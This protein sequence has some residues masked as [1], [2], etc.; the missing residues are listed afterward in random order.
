[1]KKILLLLITVIC[2]L[3]ASAQIGRE[4]TGVLRDSTGQSV[5]GATIR[6]TSPSDTLSVSSNV[7]GAFTFRNVKS[8]QFLLSISS[9]GYQ[10]LNKRFLFKEGTTPLQ[11]EPIVLKTASNV[12]NEVQV[13]ATRG[14]T[15]KEDT[16]EYRAAD[17]PVRENSV[18]EDIIKK[19][20]GVEVDRE[21]NVTTQGKSVTRVRVNGRDYFEGDLKTATQNLP[22]E[23]IDKIQIIDDYGDQAAITGIREGEADKIINIQLRTN[24]G[25]VINGTGGLGSQERYQLTGN[26]QFMN[27]DQQLAI[28][29]NLNNNNA[30]PFSFGGGGGRG[31]GGGGGRS[32]N[33]GGSFSGG[34]FGGGGG[35]GNNSG[36]ITNTT[37]GGLNFRDD[38]GK[39]VK[40][41][42]SYRFMSRNTDLISN[43]VRT[44]FIR[45]TTRTNTNVSLLTDIF[46]DRDTRTNNHNLNFNLEY[47]IDSLNY[48][49]VSPFVSISGNNTDNISNQLQQ[50]EGVN[51]Q[52][53]ELFN[54]S[55]SSSPFLGGN[56]I[57]NHRF[58][59]PGKNLSIAGT[60]GRSNNTSYQEARDDFEFF[61]E[62]E[63]R[64]SVYLRRIDVNNRS[65]NTNANVTYSEPLGKFSRLDFGYNFSKANYDNSRLTDVFNNQGVFVTDPALSNVFNYSFTTNRFS[66]NYRFD[67]QRLYNFNLGLT[68][69]PTLLDGFSETNQVSVNRKGF[70]LFPTARF[71]YNFA[72]TRSLNINYAGR[73][74]E[75]SFSQIQPVRDI[76]DI[77]RP[78]VGNPKLNAAFTQSLNISYNTTDPRTGL[79]FNAGLNGNVID[80]RITRNVVFHDQII[81]EGDTIFNVQET[82]YLNADGYYSTNANYSF[83]K[84]FAERKYRISLNGSLNFSNDVTYNNN[85]RNIGRN[86][87]IRQ[88]IRGQINPNQNLEIYPAISYRRTWLNYTLPVSNDTKAET[89]DFDLNGRVFFFKTF[90]LGLDASYNINRGY[91]SINTSPF[92]LNT[93][94]EKQFFNKRGTL[95]MQAFDVMKEAVAVNRSQGENSFTDSQNNRL[96]RYY[97]LTFS[98]RFQK[99]PGG[100]QPNFQ[101]NR[102]MMRGTPGEPRD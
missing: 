65:I 89:W 96:T 81:A 34:G 61:I 53:R 48:L 1:M 93:Y 40:V 76:S 74:T 98:Y 56:I 46:E 19:L 23:I 73:S 15:I 99:Y 16:V 21:G 101:R 58:R 64:D 7:N 4:V 38:W 9:L 35:F 82:N 90:I 50:R 72:R 43:S 100:I 49:R 80:D 33:F 54:M 29:L 20:P 51:I 24:K 63:T 6:L 57:F 52:N 11:L 27:D 95:R 22:A 45:D 102:D 12:L 10:N 47:Q 42:G 91:S 97:M 32:G 5:I 70:N 59:K 67:K 69:Q 17:F 77:Q 66:L 30:S 25:M 2:T 62:D 92:I 31:F 44:D 94:L 8:S 87:S 79:F 28:I 71:S 41:F 13:S 84:S 55:E 36:G 83:G 68:A 75:P 14:I 85:Q 26:G 18:A 78:V 37:G 3:T 60:I 88:G 39:K 86:W